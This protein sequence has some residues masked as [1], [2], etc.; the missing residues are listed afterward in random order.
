MLQRFRK[1]SPT[2]YRSSAPDPQ[3]V[4]WLNKNLG[5]TR[6]I[7]LDPEASDKIHLACELLQINHID[8]PIDYSRKSLMNF[9]LKI[10]SLFEEQEKT[11]IHCQHG[12]DRT[13][14]ACAIFRC[15]FDN[16]SSEKAIKEAEDLDFGKGL[17]PSVVHLYKSIIRDAAKPE[18]DE[19]INATMDYGR[20]LGTTVYTYPGSISDNLSWAPISDYRNN[21]EVIDGD[22]SI[23]KEFPE[24]FYSPS[25]HMDE[26][27]EEGNTIP[28]SGILNGINPGIAGA[29]FSFP[30]PL[31]SV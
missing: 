15:K 31:A 1:V 23:D 2:L 5:I 14:L 24:E 29:A 11:L 27:S 21:T 26:L 20:D 12:R 13:G 6:I 30:I 25:D 3:D 28:E 19:D 22:P 16:W 8:L 9:L 18:E 17:D 4:K 7:S 10:Q